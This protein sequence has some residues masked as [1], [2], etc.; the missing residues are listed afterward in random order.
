MLP[1]IDKNHQPGNHK[2]IEGPLSSKALFELSVF[3]TLLFVFAALFMQFLLTLYTAILLNLNSIAFQYSLFRISFLSESSSS[4]SVALVCFVF[5]SGP[6]ILSFIGFI[7]LFILGRIMDFGWKTKLALTWTAFLMVNALPCGMIAGVFFY[8]SFGMAFQWLIGDDLVRGVIALVVLMILIIF[9]RFWLRMFLKT[10]YASVFSDNVES[11]KIF[12]KTV[13]LKPWI[14][15]IIIL[16]LFNLQFTN[17]YWRVFLLSLGY[18]AIVLYDPRLK[19]FR[20]PHIRRSDK[21]IFTS[22]YQ[23]IFFVVVL[24]L[25]GLADNALI[26]F[27]D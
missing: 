18:L 19:I 25:I 17:F 11:Q 23:V 2:P 8:E 22:R 6:V 7:L 10:T 14:Y 21:K 24:I 5:G 9:S 12:I 3:S 4:W 20:K 1:L 15:G 13:F 26:Y 16:M 27:S